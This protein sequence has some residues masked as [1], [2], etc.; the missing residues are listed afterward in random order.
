MRARI[1]VILLSLLLLAL[2]STALAQD[3]EK[4]STGHRIDCKKVITLHGG[5]GGPF[6][7]ALGKQGYLGVEL[8]E[9]TPELLT[10]FGVAGEHGVLVSRV[11]EGSPAAAAGLLVGDV[12][13]RIDGEEVTS[14]WR[15][16]QLVR[17]RE[18]GDIASLEYWRDGKVSTATAT[19]AERE[20]CAFDFS[21]VIDIRPG[22]GK[23]PRLDFDFS[24]IEDLPKALGEDVWSEAMKN[25]QKTL[26]S[27]ELEGQLKR[28][29]TIDL[30]E[31]EE[32]IEKINERLR[33]LEIEIADE[34]EKVKENKKGGASI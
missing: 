1:P 32:N 5:P 14:A 11:E 6:A 30:H 18:E 34:K 31:I 29:E 27:G 10:H 22:T 25:L 7:M 26:E 23:I 3:E 28:L 19:I 33:K 4:P 12:V 20:R 13:T 21:H 9:L 16:A 2:G 8:T 15:L 17:D 24:T